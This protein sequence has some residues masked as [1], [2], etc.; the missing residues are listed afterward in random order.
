MAPE[1]TNAPA[2]G[3]DATALQQGDG[4]KD[5]DVT[6][7]A[8]V[9]YY[10]V[11]FAAFW[12]GA[13]RFDMDGDGD[14]DAADIQAMINGGSKHL[15]LNFGR[16][17][18]DKEQQ[19]KRKAARERQRAKQQQQGDAADVVIT[20]VA[21]ASVEDGD[22]EQEVLDN[23]RQYLPWFTIFNV[24]VCFVLWATFASMES[25]YSLNDIYREVSAANV[26]STVE[27]DGTL[28]FE[29][30][31]HEC[32]RNDGCVG[33]AFREG[34]SAECK[35][36]SSLPPTDTSGTISGCGVNSWGWKTY[37]KDAW[38]FGT[39]GVSKGGLEN[40]FPGQTALRSHYY[41]E[42]GFE[43]TFLYRWFTYQFTHGGLSHVA[44]NMFM[45]IVLGVPLEGLHGTGYFCLMWM[46]G[47][48]GG[49]CNWL[50]F[51]PYR[52]SFGASGGCF[53][54]LGM[55]VADLVMNWRQKKFRYMIIVVLL[56][57]SGVEVAGFWATYDGSGSVTAHCV[58]VGGLIAGL[59]VGICVGRN[60]HEEKWERS[61][62]TVCW[63]TG[64]ILV[65]LSFVW[66]FA[67]NPFPAIRNLWDPVERPWCWIG[68][69][70]I[71][72]NGG[73]CP[74][75]LAA[76]GSSGAFATFHQCVFCE[77][78]AC[79]EGWFNAQTVKNGVDQFKFCPRSFGW[80][81]CH[82]SFTAEWD[83]FYPPS[84]SSFQ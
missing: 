14:F 27:V 52:T 11:G 24:V 16:P 71:G 62:Q 51:D 49:A 79:V 65:I 78:R 76:S 66:W 22:V 69:A 72:D 8:K 32:N 64:A 36:L 6:L 57:V 21:S 44:S 63:A 61:V 53:S 48:L 28:H 19:K 9:C 35:L 70:C 59:L 54:L 4:V 73:E 38:D 31:Q 41:C 56:F 84:K 30:C 77:D 1:A 15:R 13:S 26:I 81:D 42:E 37:K 58:H 33:I 83:L 47:V 3:S 68:Q 18:Q 45:L 23:L 80:T 10:T 7:L 34:P 25:S 40:W 43:W 74:L 5:E 39:W 17:P 82:E 12:F 50:L 20:Q 60:V 55:H 2:T 29:H 75:P 67:A 46:A